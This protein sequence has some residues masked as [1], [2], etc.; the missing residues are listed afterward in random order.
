MEHALWVKFK[1]DSDESIQLTQVIEH[2][3]ELVPYV[4]NITQAKMNRKVLAGDL[5]SY[6][7]EGL[8]HAIDRYDHES[9][10]IF[11]TFAYP[12]I[13]GAMLDGLRRDDWVPRSVRQ[14][15]R[16][17]LAAQD[18]HSHAT[19]SE[20][21]ELMEVSIPALRNILARSATVLP[22]SLDEPVLRHTECDEH[23][24]SLGDMLDTSFS[25]PI[26]SRSSY[27]EY[28]ILDALSTVE[29][30]AGVLTKQE[31][32]VCNE[33]FFHD[34]KLREI[35][36]S[37]GVTESRACQVRNDA[38]RKLREAITQQHELDDMLRADEIKKDESYYFP[39]FLGSSAEQPSLSISQLQYDRTVPEWSQCERVG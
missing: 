35:G 10:N 1:D 3:A 17:L 7:Y 25:K 38:L 12:R 5:I 21:A 34:M 31:I 22:V 30:N 29:V 14:Q 18:A 8:L 11:W 23:S 36:A 13:H 20:L 24:F 27:D 26:E 19:E 32:Y 39:P 4:A 15:L 28:A 2:Y 9:G 6:G 37:L 33:Y 16:Q